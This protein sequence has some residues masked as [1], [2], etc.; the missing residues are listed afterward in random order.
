MHIYLS[1]FSQWHHPAEGLHRCLFYSFHSSGHHHKQNWFISG[2]TAKVCISS[3]LKGL[4]FTQRYFNRKPNYFELYLSYREDLIVFFIHIPVQTWLLY[5]KSC[6]TN[7]LKSF[8]PFLWLSFSLWSKPCDFYYNKHSYHYYYTHLE[9]ISFLFHLYH[10]IFLLSMSDCHSVNLIIPSWAFTTPRSFLAPDW[11]TWGWWEIQ[12][13]VYQ[14]N[15]LRNTVS[16]TSS[17]F[18]EI[19]REITI[20]RYFF[21][22]EGTISFVVK[23]MHVHIY[24]WKQLHWKCGGTNVMLCCTWK[25]KYFLMWTCKYFLT[26][27]GK[28]VCWEPIAAFKDYNLNHQ[29]NTAMHWCWAR[30]DIWRFASKALKGKAEFL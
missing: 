21:Y 28:A 6:F 29:R 26:V 5:S 12:T 30:M 20:Q 10:F 7:N 15:S 27:R 14:P 3:Y 25:K 22:F 23:C 19:L 11:P 1:S 9:T 13:Q 16:N 18:I 2:I 4:H 8:C 24:K 17:L